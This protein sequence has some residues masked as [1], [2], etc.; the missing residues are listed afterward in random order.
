MEVKN[1]LT[2]V[3]YLLSICPILGTGPVTEWRIQKWVQTTSLWD[4]E[5]EEEHGKTQAAMSYKLKTK[6]RAFLVTF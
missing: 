5:S 2:A 1:L 4:R 3:L 6:N